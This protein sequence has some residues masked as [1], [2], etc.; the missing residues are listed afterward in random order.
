MILIIQIYNVSLESWFDEFFHIEN[1]MLFLL[2]GRKLAEAD[3]QELNP[4][5][6]DLAIY[7]SFII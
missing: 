5:S 4:Q 3:E 2:F 1:V 7:F 6:G